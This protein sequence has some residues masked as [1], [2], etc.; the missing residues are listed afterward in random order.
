MLS[1]FATLL[2]G[3]CGFPRWDK[4]T[5]IY[6]HTSTDIQVQKQNI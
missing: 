1:N 2:L 6:T 4:K 5:H 3:L